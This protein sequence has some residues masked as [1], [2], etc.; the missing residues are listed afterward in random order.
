VPLG[1]GV[2]DPVIEEVDGCFSLLQSYKKRQIAGELLA[3]R[4]LSFGAECFQDVLPVI[5]RSR[6]MALMGIEGC[7]ALGKRLSQA[8]RQRDRHEAISCVSGQSFW[9]FPKMIFP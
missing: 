6:E 8:M 9:P 5:P 4:T 7:G 2:S 1:R 3:T